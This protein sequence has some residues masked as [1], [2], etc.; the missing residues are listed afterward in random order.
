MAEAVS[1][2][3]VVFGIVWGLAGGLAV[4][5]MLGRRR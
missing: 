4:L 3:V 1:F 2:V 5:V